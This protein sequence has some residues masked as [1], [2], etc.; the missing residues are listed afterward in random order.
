MRQIMRE[1][2]GS[3][4]VEVL[5]SPWPAA[6]VTQESLFEIV[7]CQFAYHFNVIPGRKSS[8]SRCSQGLHQVPQKCIL[9]GTSPGLANWRAN[10]SKA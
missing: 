10:D 2:S 7:S 1:N 5:I 3:N 8:I 9:T 6:W 4:H